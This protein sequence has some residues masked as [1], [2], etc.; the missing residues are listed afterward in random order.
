MAKLT[1]S[2]WAQLR[3]IFGDRQRMAGTVGAHGLTV[4]Q[5]KEAGLNPT[6][7]QAGV[8]PYA[9]LPLLA[10]RVGYGLAVPMVAGIAKTAAEM[11]AGGGSPPSDYEP[12]PLYRGLRR[13]VEA[14]PSWVQEQQEADRRAQEA[15]EGDVRSHPIA[16]G[17][18]ILRN[19]ALGT[20]PLMGAVAKAGWRTLRGGQFGEEYERALAEV[21][22]AQMAEEAVTEANRQAQE[23]GVPWWARGAL[24]VLAP[25]GGAEFLAGV[26][27]LFKITAKGRA[28]RAMLRDLEDQFGYSV[29]PAGEIP[30]IPALAHGQGKLKGQVAIVGEHEYTTHPTLAR[31][32]GY[33]SLPKSG[34]VR[35]YIDKETTEF[36]TADQ[37]RAKFGKSDA[38]QFW[39][40]EPLTGV[41]GAR[42]GALNLEATPTPTPT[43]T[44]PGALGLGVREV[45]G[46]GRRMASR[47]PGRAARLRS[48]IM[49]R[50]TQP[51]VEPEQYAGSR[52][53]VGSRASVRSATTQQE[54][55]EIANTGAHLKVGNDGGYVGAQWIKGPE[56]LVAMRGRFDD[57]VDQG[58]EA[59]GADWYIRT[60]DGIRLVSRGAASERRIGREWG[61]TSRQRTPETNLDM[62]VGAHNAANV[63][64]RPL[65]L[66]DEASRE[67]FIAESRGTGQVSGGPKLDPYTSNITPG[68]IG[69]LPANDIWMHRLIGGTGAPTSGGHTFLDAETM[70]AVERANERA[71]GGRTDWTGAEIQAAS[72]VAIKGRD[73]FAKKKGRW[74][75]EQALAEASKS[76]PDYFPKHTYRSTMESTP[77]APG[78]L[79]AVQ[80][81]SYAEQ[82][83][84]AAAA[85]PWVQEGDDILLRGG[86]LDLQPGTGGRM[87]GTYE[88]VTSPGEYGEA[89]VGFATDPRRMGVSERAAAQK[90]EAF[91]AVVDGQ[92]A[93]AGHYTMPEGQPGVKATELQG[94]EALT[95]RALTPDEMKRFEAVAA[96]RGGLEFVSNTGPR[97][98]A[99]FDGPVAR[100]TETSIREAL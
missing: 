45:K 74:T 27:G 53:A 83:A 22:G 8:A 99:Q 42:A 52:S 67:G 66:Y 43:A 17:G 70:L 38:T 6:P 33:A 30:V 79:P 61:A 7:T 19:E 57:L 60:Q 81:G 37:A 95:E 76:Y 29:R 82:E 3:G 88:G 54:A 56:E 15:T 21:P 9:D 91:R 73:L 85:D 80:R 41:R 72:W 14:L 18:R 64:D 4:E 1:S 86:G 68:G 39:L 13:G 97:A 11:P 65:K 90:L 10:P 100:A 49:A 46:G 77:G 44:T 16:A 55:I 32:A 2:D 28:S 35:G 93:G 71:L 58:F 50:R 98:I 12:G 36:I 34:L 63:G 69:I 75:M 59:G 23:A 48:D 5:A 96:Q 20:L 24:S 89:L 47:P 78:H 94:V 84:Y 26:G 31:Q 87:V 40:G 51:T 92:R 62:G 25:G